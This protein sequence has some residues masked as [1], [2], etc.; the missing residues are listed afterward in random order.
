MSGS[1][2]PFLPQDRRRAIARAETLPDHTQGTALFADISGFTPLTESLTQSLG[3]QRGGEELIRQINAVYESLIAQVDARDGSVISFAGDA[4][5]CWFAAPDRAG[6][7][8]SARSA[9]ACAVAMQTAM[10]S[11]ANIELTNGAHITLAIKIAL[12]SGAARR[13]IVGNPQIQLIDALAGETPAYVARAERLARPGEIIADRATLAAMTNA[14]AY[15]WRTETSGETFAVI[16]PADYTDEPPIMRAPS[17]DVLNDAQLRSWVLPGVYERYRAGL[18]EFSLELRPAVALFARVENNALEETDALIRRAQQVVARY[19]ATL[20]QLTFDDH[21]YYFYVTFGALNAHEDDAWRAVYAAFD[22]Q[23]IAR[24]AIGI[25]CGTLRV[26][27]YG[28]STRRAFGALG[29]ATNLAARLMT[30]APAGEIRCDYN[31]YRAASKRIAFETLPPIRVK[32]KAGLVR[33]YKPNSQQSTVNSQQSEIIGRRAEI[34]EI[35]KALD[36]VQ[37]GATRA[38]VI[39]GE[40]GIGKSRL[41]DELK[42]AAR[43]R[44]LTG[45]IGYGQS[46]EQ[47]TP[48]RAWR[49]VFNSYFELD[50]VTDANERRARVESLVAQLIPEH[51]PRLPVLNDVLGLDIP[52]NE[53]TRSFDANLRQQNVTLVLTALLRAW[54]NERPLVLILE[55]AHWLDGLSWNLAMQVARAL[56]LVNA[57]LLFVIV[58][59][60]LDDASTDRPPSAGQKIVAELRA[61][62]ITQSLALSALAPAAIVALITR[63]LQVAPDALP[64]P[65]VELVQTRANGNPFF[66]EELVL[67]LRDTGVIETWEDSSSQI[68]YL[69]LPDT[70]HGLI[71]SRIDHLPPERQ[72]VVKVAAVIGRAF[73]FAPLQH[74]VNR[75]VTMIAESLKEHLTSLTKANFTFLETLEPEL[76]FVFKHIITQEAAYQTLLFSQRRELHRSVAEWYENSDEWSVVSGQKIQSLSTTHYPLLAYHYRY[77]EDADKERHYLLRAGDAAEKIFAN[78]AALG[79]YTRLLT[80]SAPPAQPAI[81]LKRGKVFELV[82]R[83]AEAEQDYRAALTIAEPLP[84]GELATRVRF[85]LGD[86]FRQRAHYALA[87][88]HLTRALTAAQTLGA[89]DLQAHSIHA[90]GKILSE[91]GDYAQAQAHFEQ[92]LAVWH[93]LDDSRGQATALHAL[94][95]IAI[96]R[97][98]YAH[99]EENYAQARMI[100]HA[101]GARADEC[102]TLNNLGT[103]ALYRGEY[104]RAANFYAD[105]LA[106]AREIGARR[107][108]S[109]ALGNLGIVA[110]YQQDYAR[111]M[112]YTEQALEID[113]AMGHQQGMGRK[114]NALGESARAQGDYARARTYYAEALTIARTTGER[115]SASIALG[116]LG[117]VA[118]EQRAYAAALAQYTEAATIANELGDR[119]RIGYALTGLAEA[120]CGVGQFADAEATIR[121]A[122]A[123]R[124]QVGQQALVMESVAGLARIFLAQGK[125]TLALDAAQEILAY[126]DRDQPLEAANEPLRILLTCFHVLARNTQPRAPEI[127]ALTFR[128]LRERLARIADPNARRTVIA[129][130]PWNREIIAAWATVTGQSHEHV[131][132]EALTPFGE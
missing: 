1:L 80:L 127:L 4:L 39:E 22:L 95:N 10:H 57:P 112:A 33:V 72:F 123:V 101:I 24:L 78:D 115:R 6:L 12:A 116:N 97:A 79:F 91:E 124:R 44:G 96:F 102:N 73:A 20:I 9:L 114:A 58:N 18:A 29:D 40:A 84:N 26:G 67:H 3:A 77:A 129:Q 126:V 104:D 130:S 54:T 74:V 117:L 56:A 65:L 62:P 13:M 81:R 60:P 88:E 25:S 43:E 21:G 111:A 31:V 92:A 7:Q 76:T 86:L 94:G 98:D 23:Q 42:R 27:A 48:Y 14:P 93:A 105:A 132:A 109:N 37:A 85:H 110:H 38:L 63:R 50:T 68:S 34:A 47:Q 69:V 66:A 49:D 53:L 82:G 11:F 36:A 131:I 5:L 99:A 107:N 122:I 118:L 108:E 64:A 89:R 75:Y 15:E 46:I 41:V 8:S 121:K 28:A 90:L 52:E 17:E 119:D 45:L 120:Q 2:I 87:R 61:L 83:W 70:L 59:R 16:A 19:D 128:R 30:V 71:L 100:F 51:A 35:E 103:V 125:P 106:R 32:G 113:R 55:D